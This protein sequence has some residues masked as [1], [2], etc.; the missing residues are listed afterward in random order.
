MNTFEKRLQHIS[1]AAGVY[2]ILVPVFNFFRE[3]GPLGFVVYAS[4]LLIVMS[5]IAAA[6][7]LG[8]LIN[9]RRP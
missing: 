9:E 1:W 6:F 3:M 4:T 2:G 8:Q 5:L 7:A